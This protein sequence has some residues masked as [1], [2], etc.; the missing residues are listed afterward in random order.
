MQ[1]VI[2]VG[3]KKKKYIQTFIYSNYHQILQEKQGV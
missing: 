2:Y 1:T 3:F